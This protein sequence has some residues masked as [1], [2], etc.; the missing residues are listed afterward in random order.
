[1]DAVKDS[2]TKCINLDFSWEEDIL[3]IE[4]SDT[5]PGIKTEEQNEIFTKGYSTKG[6]NRG[7]GLYLIRRSLERLGGQ[8]AVI[9][10]VGH[11]ALFRVIIPYWSKEEYFD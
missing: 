3:T 5:G 10:E 8:I 2:T 7:V 11:G 4:V 6:P 1:M 9:S